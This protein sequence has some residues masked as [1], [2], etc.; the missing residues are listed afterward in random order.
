MYK[1]VAFSACVVAALLIGT[2]ADAAT[3]W[4]VR[5]GAATNCTPDADS[6]GANT[7]YTSGLT[8]LAGN[9]GGGLG[10]DAQANCGWTQYETNVV[11]ATQD[12]VNNNAVSVGADIVTDGTRAVKVSLCTQGYTTSSCSTQISS[13]CGGCTVNFN[14]TST[15]TYAA[16]PW[17]MGNGNEY[18]FVNFYMALP[19]DST[20]H[21]ANI[22]GLYIHN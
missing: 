17:G 4:Y 11:G 12:Y 21:K 20:E 15:P 5:T 3:T 16:T 13:T 18:D 22:A 8:V 1:A 10:G 7:Y 6:S 2:A 14:S 9:G 19:P